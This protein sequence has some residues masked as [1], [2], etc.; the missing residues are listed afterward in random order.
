[1]AAKQTGTLAALLCFKDTKV[2][3]TIVMQ[4][5]DMVVFTC[6]NSATVCTRALVHCYAK[7]TPDAIRLYLNPPLHCRRLGGI[8]SLFHW[9]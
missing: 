3:A 8:L 5:C 9:F 6:P 1:M 7:A 2:G 4:N